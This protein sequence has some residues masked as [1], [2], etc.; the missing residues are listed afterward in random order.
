MNNFEIINEKQLDF[1]FKYIVFNNNLNGYIDDL[2]KENMEISDYII[3]NM[4]KS[5]QTDYYL[6]F[7]LLNEWLEIKEIIFV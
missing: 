6:L 1:L 7:G 2:E 5:T 3:N 4:E